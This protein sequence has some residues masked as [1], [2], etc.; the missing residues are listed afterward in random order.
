MKENSIFREPEVYVDIG[1]I[2]FNCT[3]T[4]NGAWTFAQAAHF[5]QIGCKSVYCVNLEKMVVNLVLNVE[6]AAIFYDIKN[7][8]NSIG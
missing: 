8:S 6:S 2:P 4:I 3:E 7:Y 5:F 1:L